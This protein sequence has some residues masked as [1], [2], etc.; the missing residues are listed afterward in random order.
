[1]RYLIRILCLILISNLSADDIEKD[2]QTQFILA[3][4]GDT[5]IIPEG[6]H[7]IIGTLSIDGKKNLIIRGF[8]MDKSILSFTDQ[9][10]G[11]QGISIT[12]S[13][14]ITLQGFTV[15]DAKGDAIKTQYVDGIIFRAIT[16]EW[17]GGPK[18]SNGAYG[19]YPVQCTNVLIEFCIANGASDAG[20]YVGQSKDIIVRNS[21]AFNNV[22]GIEIENSINAKVYENHSYNNTGG[23]LIFDLPDLVQ[24]KGDNIHIYQNLIENNNL[25]NFAPQGNIVGKVLPGTGVMILA[26][27]NVHIY[28]NT[29]RNNKSVGTGIVSYF[30]TEE[31]M[32]DNTYNPY[33]SDIHIYSNIFDRK[34]GLPT[35]D[36]EIGQ[37]MAIKYGRTIPDI[38]YDGMQDPDISAG[39]C[40]QNNIESD[41]TNLD[42][43]HNFENW[44]SPFISN[45]SEDKSNF[46]CISNHRISS[47]SY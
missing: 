9:A 13:S 17:T 43:E 35:L 46:K 26:A 27:N 10:E 24:T 7:N 42:I 30:I 8:G 22:A 40:L 33:T 32:T 19:L 29:I 37:L 28:E 11:A 1:M 5:I 14:N 25:N 39:L 44:Y 3:E 23:I 31:P 21:K 38:I 47:N 45:F 18:P 6:L 12:N 20:I 4:P 16:T 41:F 36:Y 34:V 2:L 15:R